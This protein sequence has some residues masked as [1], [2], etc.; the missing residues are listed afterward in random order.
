MSQSLTENEEKNVFPILFISVLKVQQNKFHRKQIL[1]KM[2]Q[3]F[4]TSWYFF[5][6]S[7]EISQLNKLI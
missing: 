7:Q 5:K 1:R 6:S 3:F 4:K 2:K